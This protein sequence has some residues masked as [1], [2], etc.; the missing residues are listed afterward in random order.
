MSPKIIHLASELSGGA[1]LASLRLHA[2]LLRRGVDSH[3]LHGT[4]GSSLPQ[5]RRLN[6]TGSSWRH[7][8]DR[9]LDQVVWK[10][11][12]P[13]ATLFTRTR[14]LVHGGIA[15][16]LQG[17]DL[18]H[19]HWI[20]KWLDW[21]AVFSAIPEDTPIVFTLH[22]AGFFTGGCHQT[23]VCRRFEERCRHCPVL[24]RPGK[25]DL[26]AQGFAQK[27]KI[28][29]GRP[30]TIVP[31]S[32]WMASHSS[33]A[34]LLRPFRQHLPIFPGIDTEIFRPR[35][36]KVCRDLL[37]VA[38]DHFVI[39]AGAADLGDTNKGMQIL[40]DALTHLPEE[41]RNRCTMVTYGSGT[42][43]QQHYG[44]TIHQCG[45]V[46]SENLLSAIYSAADLYC[47]PSLMET[48]GMTAAEAGACGLPVIAFATGG[49]TEIVQAGQTGWSVPLENGAAGLSHSLMDAFKDAEK[50]RAHGA[51]ARSAAV[52]RLSISEGA[53]AY[54]R[55][56][57]T[58]TSQ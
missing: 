28:L 41:V 4:G 51:Q 35:D 19:F 22:D 43:P 58:L 44:V 9:L 57:R 8:G 2:A 47:T 12:A 46:G 5:T 45:F 40:L 30:I 31:N 32:A 18:V 29:A 34:A 52:N 56:Y 55:L 6:P 21:T 49:L 38:Q 3:L 53:V 13:G 16:A 36:Q 25:R 26:A 50:R 54:E 27:E 11:R 48:F 33:N 42:L 15:E 20:A 37:G 17:A 10:A 23:N 1:G 24:R 14:R 39:C 7:Y